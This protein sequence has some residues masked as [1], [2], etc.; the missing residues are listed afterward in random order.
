[1]AIVGKLARKAAE[2]GGSVGIATGSAATAVGIGVAASARNKK[3]NAVKINNGNQATAADAKRTD[4]YTKSET[5]LPKKS[6]GSAFAEAR[7]AGKSVFEWNGKKYNT[8]LREEIG[9]K[10]SNVREGVNRNID[11]ETRKRA[12]NFVSKK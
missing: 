2:K 11:D 9:K 6:F 8:K 3:D 4:S 1:M 5:P 12:M 10:T 7:K